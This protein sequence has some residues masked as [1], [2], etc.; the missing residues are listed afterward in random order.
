V[1]LLGRLAKM[2]CFSADWLRWSGNVAD[3]L[4]W[5][6]NAASRPIG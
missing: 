3:W 1:P 6:G 4:K 2:E 5:S